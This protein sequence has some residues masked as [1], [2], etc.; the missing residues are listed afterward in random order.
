M[1]CPQPFPPA[2]IKSRCCQSWALLKPRAR[3]CSSWQ[4]CLSSAI[5]QLTRE[6]CMM[7]RDNRW[8]RIGRDSSGKPRRGEQQS[9][10]KGFCGQVQ[11]AVPGSP[12]ASESER[13]SWAEWKQE[14][15]PQERDIRHLNLPL[16][17]RL[18]LLR[19]LNPAGMLLRGRRDRREV[20]GKFILFV[21]WEG[22]RN[23][24]KDV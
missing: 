1:W 11:G 23:K 6:L 10:L 19:M 21:G 22:R 8:S 24:W 9:T 3:L 16:S 18:C 12:G 4:L 15:C 14:L 13:C 5:C 17:P 20:E 7:E 2:E